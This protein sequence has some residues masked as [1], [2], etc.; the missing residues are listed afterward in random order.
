M[1]IECFGEPF[2][3]LFE[4]LTVETNYMDKRS[5][6]KKI[7]VDAR[8]PEKSRNTLSIRVA[9]GQKSKPKAYK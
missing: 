6:K 8:I 2:K 1:I 5:Y 3:L 7:T 4:T 9:H